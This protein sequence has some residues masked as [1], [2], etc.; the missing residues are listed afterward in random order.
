MWSL[1]I[2][3]SSKEKTALA[4]E[5][6]ASK[7]EVAQL[8]MELS[9]ARADLLKVQG[10][11][12]VLSTELKQVL[13]CLQQYYVENEVLKKGVLQLGGD[14]VLTK[15]LTSSK[16]VTDQLYATKPKSQSS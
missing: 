7:S 5:L 10:E 13:T 8:E 4:E 15:L 2:V 11:E 3:E 9:D 6:E 14:E 1:L 12:G 16:D